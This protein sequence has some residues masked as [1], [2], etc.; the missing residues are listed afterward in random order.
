[1][2]RPPDD[3][4]K[5]GQPAQR[6]VRGNAVDEGEGLEV[7]EVREEVDQAE[8]HQRDDRTSRPDDN[9]QATRSRAAASWR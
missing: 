5:D 9:G 7:K 6:V 3:R 8:Q 4:H 2:M 1:M